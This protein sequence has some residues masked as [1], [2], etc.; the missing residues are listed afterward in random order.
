ME[1]R[2]ECQT[3]FDWSLNETVRVHWQATDRSVLFRLG[4]VFFCGYL[5]TIRLS[6]DSACGLSIGRARAH[7]RSTVNSLPRSSD[8]SSRT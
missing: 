8:S 6:V 1:R 5:R 2:G 7:S 3:T 4:C